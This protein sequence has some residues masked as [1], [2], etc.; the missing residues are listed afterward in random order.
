LKRKHLRV[1]LSDEQ[2]LTLGLMLVILLALSLLYC[3]GFAS[4]ALRRAWENTDL[5]WTTP[6]TGPDIGEEI[7][8]V[9]PALV[10]PAT[11]SPSPT[12]SSRLYR[13]LEDWKTERLEA[14]LSI[15]HPASL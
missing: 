1:Q 12:P 3:L 15:F 11:P 5:P 7:L 4:L 9:T 14:R 13:P 6:E 10:T 2:Q 8:D